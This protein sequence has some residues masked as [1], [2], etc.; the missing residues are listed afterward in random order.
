MISLND[1]LQGRHITYAKEYHPSVAENAKMLL[2][3]VNALISELDIPD[4]PILVA[5]GWRPETYNR[6]IGGSPHSYHIKGMAID[7]VD[8]EQW[9]SQAIEATPG[10]LTRYGLWMEDPAHTRTWCHLDIGTR[11]D[12]PVRIFLP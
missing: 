6:L 9:I 11:Q 5:S 12:R 10:L 1:Y 4:G 2:E 8:D 7:L 3:K